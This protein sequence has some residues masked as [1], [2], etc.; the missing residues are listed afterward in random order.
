MASLNL[1]RPMLPFQIF[2]RHGLTRQP[3]AHMDKSFTFIIF[4]LLF[5]YDQPLMMR[6][7]HVHH[8]MGDHFHRI[9]DP[10]RC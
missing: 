1:P 3:F 5:G 9:A 10:R 6:L 4:A 2:D 7:R 8:L